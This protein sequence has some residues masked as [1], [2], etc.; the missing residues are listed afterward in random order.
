MTRVTRKQVQWFKVFSERH[1]R[2][3]YLVL[4]F[5]TK[6][7]LRGYAA[8]HGEIDTSRALGV[9]QTYVVYRE[10]N[11]CKRTL[12]VCG[13]I[14][15][16]KGYLTPGIVAHEVT[17]AALGWAARRRVQVDRPLNVGTVSENEERFCYVVGHMTAQICMKLTALGLLNTRDDIAG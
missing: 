16:C 4:I 15:L 8:L 3:H 2:L 5:E 10:R 1:S 12:P 17:H 11:A 7:D 6:H 13:E 14:L 9:T